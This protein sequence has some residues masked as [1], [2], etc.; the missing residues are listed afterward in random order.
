MTDIPGHYNFRSEITQKLKS[1]KAIIITLDSKD[2]SKYGEAAEI[3]YDI[4]GDIDVISDKVPILIACNKQDLT[5][6]RNSLKLEKDLTNEIE[7]IR[8]VRMASRQ[9]EQDTANREAHE[10]D[11]DD[12]QEI[13]YI[14]TLKGK[15]AFNQLPNKIQFSDCQ[16][17]NGIIDEILKFIK[18]HV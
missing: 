16:V 7:Q 10:E 4:L 18:H 3:L 15:F 11:E 9:Q 12:R 2:K 5:F 8:K 14:E 17:K 1:A 13:G 6:A